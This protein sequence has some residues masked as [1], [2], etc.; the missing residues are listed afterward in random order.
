MKSVERR[1]TVRAVASEVQWPRI[2][3]LICYPFECPARML[4]LRDNLH[5]KSKPIS[6]KKIGFD[7]SCTSL[8]DKGD[9]LHE[10]SNSIF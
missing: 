7:I 1:G 9:S 6:P 5:E 4:V 8:G 10:N 3:P 2:V